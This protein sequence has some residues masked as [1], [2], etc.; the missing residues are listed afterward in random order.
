MRHGVAGDSS[1]VDPSLSPR[2][3]SS[4]LKSCA[5]RE[6][7]HSV[8][9]AITIGMGIAMAVTVSLRSGNWAAPSLTTLASLSLTSRGSC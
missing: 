9:L 6:E 7:L 8:D 3:E 5:R 2:P 1:R 4:C